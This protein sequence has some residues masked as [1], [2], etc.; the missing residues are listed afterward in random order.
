MY[1]YLF[2]KLWSNIECVIILYFIH[3]NLPQLFEANL[4]PTLF[5]FVLLLLSVRG[6]LK[7]KDFAF[8]LDL[9]CFSRL[10]YD[11][12]VVSHSRMVPHGLTWFCVVLHGFA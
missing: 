5:F 8:S 4:N 1:S 2:S 12:C 3:N 6:F 10:P 11:F 7:I 9:Q